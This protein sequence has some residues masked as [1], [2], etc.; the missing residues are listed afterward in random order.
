M[1]VSMEG[2]QTLSAA[3]EIADKVESLVRETLPGADV[4]VHAEPKHGACDT[5]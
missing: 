2:E 4:T 3:H 5:Q 1:H